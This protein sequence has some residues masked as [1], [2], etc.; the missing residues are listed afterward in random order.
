M[1]NSL[2]GIRN[3]G[4]TCYINCVIQCLRHCKDFK[5]YLLSQKFIEDLDKKLIQTDNKVILIESF[6]NI[7]RKTLSTPQKMIVIPESFIKKFTYHFRQIALSQNDSHEALIFL[8]DLFHEMISRPVKITRV[9]NIS[10]EAK[11]SWEQFYSKNFSYIIKI[12]FGQHETQ[13]LCK[14]CKHISKTFVPFNHLDVEFSNNLIK[15]IEQNFIAEEVDRKCEEC[16]HNKA[17]KK[18]LISML[19]NNLILQIKRFK[20]TNRGIVKKNGAIDI[21]EMLDLSKYY[22]YQNRY[23]LYNLYAGIVHYGTPNS[24]HYISFC[25]SDDFWYKYDDEH[26]SKITPPDLEYFKQNAYVLFYKKL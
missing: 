26:V 4:N 25:K 2:F 11:K 19:P 20:Y 24:G 8:L 10:I 12:F 5:E 3:M 6:A 15:S 18:T 9:T 14:Q 16:N 21:P 17:L 7:I 13:I 23:G 1:K 22:V